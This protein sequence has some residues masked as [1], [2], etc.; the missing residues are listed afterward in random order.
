[1]TDAVPAGIDQES[2]HLQEISIRIGVL[3]LLIKL[4]RAHLMNCVNDPQID[5]AF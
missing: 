3:E 1:V 2:S 5:V 4:V